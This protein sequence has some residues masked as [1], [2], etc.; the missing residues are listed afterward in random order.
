MPDDDDRL[1]NDVRDAVREALERE[2]PPTRSRARARLVSGFAALP[3]PSKTRRK[4][5]NQIP[6]VSEDE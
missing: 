2:V 6:N 4:R 5:R 3:D 1:T